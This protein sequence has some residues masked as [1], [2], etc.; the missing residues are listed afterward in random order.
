VVVRAGLLEP[1]AENGDCDAHDAFGP[2]GL[3]R[4]VG[5]ETPR[6]VGRLSGVPG[7]LMGSEASPIRE[8]DEGGQENQRVPKGRPPVDAAT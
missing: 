6:S 2:G 7:G 8:K 4:A 3:P 1:L 5:L